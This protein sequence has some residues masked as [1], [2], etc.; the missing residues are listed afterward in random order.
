M[1]CCWVC[2]PPPSRFSRPP[3]RA[4]R[5]LLHL[6]SSHHHH[7]RQRPVG[8]VQRKRQVG[9]H[10]MLLLVSCKHYL[11]VHCSLVR[12]QCLLACMVPQKHYSKA[13]FPRHFHPGSCQAVLHPFTC[14]FTHHKHTSHP[15]DTNHAT[16]HTFH[17]NKIHTKYIYE[18]VENI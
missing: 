7:H 14:V 15:P 18:I 16:Q 8:H 5:S 13:L 12:D 17:K 10:S 11:L 2:P 3:D 1:T 9:W 6:F 4:H